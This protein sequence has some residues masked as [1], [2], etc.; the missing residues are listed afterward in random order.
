MTIRQQLESL[1]KFK[2]DGKRWVC[3]DCHGVS[4]KKRQEWDDYDMRAIDMCR[5]GCDL[6]EPIEDTIAR[7]EIL[8]K[9]ADNEAI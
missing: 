1:I 8:A 2:K 7:F 3:L 6:F 4:V 5:C 9:E